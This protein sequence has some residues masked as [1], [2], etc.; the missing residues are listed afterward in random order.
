MTAYPGATD[1]PMTAM[2][3]AGPELG[4]NRQPAPVVAAA[5][6]AR[7]ERGAFEVV[8]GGETRAKIVAPDWDNINPPDDRFLDFNRCW[9]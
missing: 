4:F 7:I 6:V 2:N 3:Q 5:T 8:R 1:V 9:K